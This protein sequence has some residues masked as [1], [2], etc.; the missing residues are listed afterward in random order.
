METNKL[1]EYLQEVKTDVSYIKNMLDDIV[2]EYTCGLD[3][4]MAKVQTEI[5]NV[6][7]PAIMTIEKYFLELSNYLYFMCEKIEKLGVYDSISKTKAQ[8]VYNMKYLE[9]QHINDGKV[10]NKKPTVAESQVVSEN[11][12]IYE[13]TINDIYNKAYKIIKAKVNSAEMMVSTLSKIFS[14]RMQESQLSVSQTH[15][16]ILNEGGI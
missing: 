4:I 5:I 15:R 13:K 2:L 11:A 14:Y 16:Q 6:D 12:S 1:P 9:H 8:E 10:G 7:C 3:D